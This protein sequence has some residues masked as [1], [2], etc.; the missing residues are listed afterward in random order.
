MSCDCDHDHI[1]RLRL[2]T[3]TTRVETNPIIIARYVSSSDHN[4]HVLFRITN[5]N[6][7]VKADGIR[8][9]NNL[10]GLMKLILMK[11]DRLKGRAPQETIRFDHTVREA[12]DVTVYAIQASLY[13]CHRSDTNH[14][15]STAKRDPPT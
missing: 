7:A 14:Q 6:E 10:D 9:Y 11:T 12:A 13:K 1:A 2:P 8:V 15:N 4:R 3:W 5:L